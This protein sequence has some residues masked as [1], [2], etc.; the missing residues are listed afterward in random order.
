[1][2]RWFHSWQSTGMPSMFLSIVLS[3]LPLLTP[4]PA[5]WLRGYP[6]RPGILGVVGPRTMPDT[7]R[8][9][10]TIPSSPS[11]NPEL[12]NGKGPAWR[13][14]ELKTIISSLL[15][16][17]GN[18]YITSFGKLRQ[19]Q[20]GQEF[21]PTWSGFSLSGGS[22]T[23]A[24]VWIKQGAAKRFILSMVKAKKLSLKAAAFALFH[25]RQ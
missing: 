15:R 19:H 14:R 13:F 4:P 25:T 3:L 16:K 24:A 9:S 5:S 17:I 12:N 20:H 18:T 22:I 11:T 21:P 6:P 23:V 2:D 7:A 1:M 10:S 8:L